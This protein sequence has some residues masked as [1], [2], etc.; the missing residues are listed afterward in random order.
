MLSAFLKFAES[1]VQSLFLIMVLWLLSTT[2]MPFCCSAARV[3]VTEQRSHELARRDEFVSLCSPP[4]PSPHL[5]LFA[6]LGSLSAW[7]Q[8]GSLVCQ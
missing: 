4:T 6:H 7:H 8:T 2:E 3:I 5:C 1:S